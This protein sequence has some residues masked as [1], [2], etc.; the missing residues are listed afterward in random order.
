ME[1]ETIAGFAKLLRMEFGDK[2]EIHVPKAICLGLGDN[3][4][5]RYVFDPPI[6]ADMDEQHKKAQIAI[7]LI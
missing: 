1:S 4:K 3:S 7:N 5:N 6:W 2:V